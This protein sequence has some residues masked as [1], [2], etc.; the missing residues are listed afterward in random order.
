MQSLQHRQALIQ[1]IHLS[2]ADTR[3]R[4]CSGGGLV[5]CTGTVAL[6]RPELV[7]LHWHNIEADIEA[8]VGQASG[9]GRT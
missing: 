7:D 6:D 9:K 4:T 2:S 3:G 5:G 8:E 1:A